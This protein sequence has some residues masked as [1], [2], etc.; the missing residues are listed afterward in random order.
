YGWRGI[1]ERPAVII[2]LNK[3]NK[4]QF[5]IPGRGRDR[6]LAWRRGC[7]SRWASRRQFQAKQNGTM[8]AERGRQSCRPGRLLL[9]RLVHVCM[10]FRLRLLAQLADISIVAKGWSDPKMRGR[11]P[12]SPL[13]NI[14]L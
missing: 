6:D 8:Q 9:A 12:S 13:P 5:V 14:V 3:A 1:R 10:P 11:M 4:V 7:F 2:A